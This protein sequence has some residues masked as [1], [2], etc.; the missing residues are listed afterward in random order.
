MNSSINRVALSG[1]ITEISEPKKTPDGENCTF[2]LYVNDRYR[3]FSIDVIC[4]DYGAEI[5]AD[6]FKSNDNVT[7]FGRLYS[8][9]GSLNVLASAVISDND[10]V[11]PDYYPKDYAVSQRN[12][13]SEQE[14]ISAVAEEMADPENDPF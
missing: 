11:V 1:I 9:D 12:D 7:V 8:R 3:Q 5:T 13:L 6:K 10:N 14:K 2:T 4:K